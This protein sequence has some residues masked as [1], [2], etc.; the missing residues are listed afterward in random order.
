MKTHART[1]NLA[2]ELALHIIKPRGAQLVDERVALEPLF[3]RS[4]KPLV[5]PVQHPDI[6]L[7]PHR[8]QLPPLAVLVCGVFVLIEKGEEHISN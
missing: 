8:I 1:H 7:H 2:D 3:D 5:E 4:V 6:L